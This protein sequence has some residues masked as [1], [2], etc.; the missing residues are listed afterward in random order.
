MDRSATTLSWRSPSGAVQGAIRITEQGE[1]I[2]AK[3][4]C[5]YREVAGV[6]AEA[7]ACFAEK[8]PGGLSTVAGVVVS[9]ERKNTMSLDPN[10]KLSN[11]QWR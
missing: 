5:E 8:D 4:C 11:A 3:H 10:Q 9:A 1:V 7:L 6:A 2:A